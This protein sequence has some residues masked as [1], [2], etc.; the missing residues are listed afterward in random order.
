MIQE[1]R[2]LC[3][4]KPHSSK[5][6]SHQNSTN[7][8]MLR[9][10]VAHS[11]LHQIWS[12]SCDARLEWKPSSRPRNI[13]VRFTVQRND[14]LQT[15]FIKPRYYGTKLD[16]CKCLQQL[17]SWD[18]YAHWTDSDYS[19]EFTGSIP[20][21]PPMTVFRLGC[22]SF[23]VSFLPFPLQSPSTLNFLLTI[24]SLFH[25]FFE[26]S[27]PALTCWSEWRLLITVSSSVRRPRCRP[28]M[29]PL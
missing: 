20:W 24:R 8:V 21:K 7:H 2:N 3:T 13:L 12:P 6:N 27:R 11:K 4:W 18:S 9:R 5:H 19:L 15:A 23:I 10:L 16:L 1:F 25:A 17:S 22:P 29:T 14:L 26:W 28:W